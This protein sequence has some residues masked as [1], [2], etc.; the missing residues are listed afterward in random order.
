M[1]GCF[2]SG[3]AQ[4]RDD[5]GT[6]HLSSS[7]CKCARAR[8]LSWEETRPAGRMGRAGGTAKTA[9]F[10]A[11]ARGVMITALPCQPHP[12][13]SCVWLPCFLVPIISIRFQAPQGCLGQIIRSLCPQRTEDLRQ[14]QR[15]KRPG[16][17][18]SSYDGDPGRPQSKNNY[19][20]QSKHFDPDPRSLCKIRLC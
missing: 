18:V 11:K 9:Q 3:C 10:T 4:A 13:S 16:I 8:S 6:I 12:S 14:Q 17:C 20:A 1:E 7:Q 2:R 5:R 19:T 15:T